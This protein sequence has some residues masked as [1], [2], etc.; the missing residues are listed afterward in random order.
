MIEKNYFNIYLIFIFN[1]I[2]IWNNSWKNIFKCLFNVF[3]KC[4][5]YIIYL[6][7]DDKKFI[8]HLFN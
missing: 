2:F 4:L 1:L 3:I 5:F 8:S 6:K 7:C